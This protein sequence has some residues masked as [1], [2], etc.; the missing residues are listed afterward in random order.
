IKW[1]EDATNNT[2]DY[3]RNFLRHQVVPL[4]KEINPSIESAIARSI[5]KT[6]GM[7]RLAHFGLDHWRQTFVKHAGSTIEI[8]KA[9]IM[10]LGAS[11]LYVFL[12]TFGFNL[13]QCISI[14]QCL[15]Q[16]SGKK[17][18]GG[19]W[20]LTVDREDIIL[21][22]S[23]AWAETII[24]ETEKEYSL[25]TKKLWVDLSS[26]P[27]VSHDK[28][29]ATLDADKVKL[30]LTWRP[31]K[32]GDAFHPLGTQHRKKLSDFFIDAKFSLAD[33]ANATVLESQG[34]IIWV[35]GERIDD[36]YKITPQTL[37]TIILDCRF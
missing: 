9:G 35:V 26:G 6:I 25:G 8:R 30:P 28:N 4:L 2:D 15:D 16:Q 14:F 31:W 12:K 36:H 32:E 1:R 34:S 29:V 37:R 3:Q 20:E 17:F 11:G 18:S 27:Q 5:D 33:K 19:K 23:K 22:Q 7:E 10:Q 13:E 21:F 24:A